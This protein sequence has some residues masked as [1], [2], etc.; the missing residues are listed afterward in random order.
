MQRFN[1]WL[2]EE[3]KEFFDYRSVANKLWREKLREAR[4]EFQVEFADENDDG[5]GQREIT[6]PQ[7]E[8]DHTECKFKCEMRK[9]C[10]DWESGVIYFRCQTAK[11]YAYGHNHYQDQYFCYIPRKNEG[12]SHLVV[13]GKKQ[14]APD[15]GDENPDERLA[16]K[17]L[18]KYLD[19]LVKKEIASVRK[20][21]SQ[22]GSNC[23]GDA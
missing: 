22:D 7:D 18:T 14:Y 19:G 6:I 12:N 8:W 17:S 20:H 23:E 13:N 16:W 21:R 1:R 11:G 3:K 9:A 10:G 5:L 15:S 2:C 4:K